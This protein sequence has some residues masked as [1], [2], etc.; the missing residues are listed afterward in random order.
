MSSWARCLYVCLFVCLFIHAFLESWGAYAPKD[1]RV[2]S[3]LPPKQ[4]PISQRSKDAVDSGSTVYLSLMT[5]LSLI[6]LTPMIIS[7]LDHPF[8]IWYLNSCN[9]IFDFRPPLYNIKV[10]WLQ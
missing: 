7:T 9:N 4:S 10:D 8:T 5:A 6:W 3:E 2:T 1:S